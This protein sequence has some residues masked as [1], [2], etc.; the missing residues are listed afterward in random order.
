MVA[1]FVGV[2]AG[3][4]FGPPHPFFR[5]F[6]IAQHQVAHT[7]QCQEAVFVAPLVDGEIEMFNRRLIVAGGKGLGEIRPAL[8]K[9]GPFP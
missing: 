5:F 7:H 1:Q 4:L 9:A 3:G 6:P 2:L 8:G